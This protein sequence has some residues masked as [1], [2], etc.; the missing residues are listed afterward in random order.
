MHELIV[1]VIMLNVSKST[2]Y[3]TVLVH[4]EEKIYVEKSWTAGTAYTV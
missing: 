3:K 1:P 4:T 2:E